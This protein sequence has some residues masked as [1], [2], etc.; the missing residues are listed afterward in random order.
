M[1]DQFAAINSSVAE[2]NFPSEITPTGL[3]IR[4]YLPNSFADA[5]ALGLSEGGR[6]RQEQLAEAVAGNIA[7]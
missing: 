4:L 2:R 1:R 3:L 7:A 5:V 6:D